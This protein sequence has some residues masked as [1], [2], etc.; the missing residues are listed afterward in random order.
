MADLIINPWVPKTRWFWKQSDWTF[1]RAF[2]ILKDW[3]FAYRPWAMA[4]LEKTS[5]KCVDERFRKTG[6]YMPIYTY[7][8]MRKDM[9][10]KLYVRW[11]VRLDTLFMKILDWTFYKVSPQK[12]T[13]LLTTLQ[14]YF[15]SK[16]FKFE[17]IWTPWS[18]K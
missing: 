18:I 9:S 1:R 6:F 14:K 12:K 13:Q 10:W 16:W 15:A 7:I 5:R 17:R 11:L 3:I 2:K 4:F 8:K